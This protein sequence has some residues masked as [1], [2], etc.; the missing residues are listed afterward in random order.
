[1]CAIC[2]EAVIVFGLGSPIVEV[3]RAYHHPP[4]REQIE[5]RQRAIQGL[6]EYLNAAEDAEREREE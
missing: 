3:V 2:E 4:T 6:V 5:A 1:M